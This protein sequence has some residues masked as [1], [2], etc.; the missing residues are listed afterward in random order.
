MGY[1]HY[2]HVTTSQ[3]CGNLQP[4]GEFLSYSSKAACTEAGRRA[5]NAPSFWRL[6]MQH[7]VFAEPGQLLRSR[8]A[9]SRD[10][11]IQVACELLSA[12][13]DVRPRKSPNRKLVDR[14]L[15]LRRQ[16]MS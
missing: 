13:F 7:V 11:A 10:A 16:A 4:F 6:P 5:R 3:H 9:R 2:P 14:S 12:D 15:L 1:R 8:V